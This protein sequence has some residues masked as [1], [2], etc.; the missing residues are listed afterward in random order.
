MRRRVVYFGLLGLAVLVMACGGESPSQTS[1]STPAAPITKVGV[2]GVISG[3]FGELTFN[4]QSLLT[5]GT[6]VT[7]QGKPAAVAKIQ[8]GAVIQGTATKTPQ[9]LQLQSVDVHHELEG[10]I[11]SVDLAGSRIVVMGQTIKVDALTVIAE[12]GPGG[13]PASLTLADLRVGDRVEVYGTT[14][15]E[16]IVLA[17]RIE[18]EPA[19][20]SL[21]ESYHG[22]VSGLNTTAKTFVASGY[23][24]SYGTAQVIGLLA[25]GVK[26]EFQGTL[27]GM[28]LTATSVQV[29]AAQENHEAGEL[30]LCGTVSGLDTTAKTFLLMSYQVS[31]ANAKV[32]GTLA[33][34]ARVEVEG[35]LGVGASPALE[36][37]E[38][39]VSY[40][41]TGSGA[42]DQ[43]KKGTIT[44]IHATDKTITLETATFWTDAAT[45]FVKGDA[46]VVFAD[47]TLGLRVELHVLSTKTNAVGQAYAAKV[48]IR[49]P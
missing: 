48:E 43:D 32:E 9:G 26:V 45:L 33:D 2:A 11:D 3:T 47:L 7:A 39:E 17:S 46:Q 40:G 4:G 22:T 15:P 16:G 21:E 1:A 30:E 23:F 5:G 34:G 35:T 38:V 14:T 19:T 18:R 44:A 42:S 49:R 8:A 37:R 12:E 25:D 28:N 36:A 24:V 29:D 31:Y 10:I 6:S 20:S 41:F 27:V 13:T